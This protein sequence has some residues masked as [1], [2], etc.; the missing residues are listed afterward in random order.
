MHITKQKLKVGPDLKTTNFFL[1]AIWEV[2]L[3]VF[4]IITK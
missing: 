4:L 2:S 1:N 3:P